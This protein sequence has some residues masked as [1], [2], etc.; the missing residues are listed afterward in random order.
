MGLSDSLYTEICKHQYVQLEM[1]HSD[2][3]TIDLVENQ[4]AITVHVVK[5]S[6]HF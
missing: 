2:R 3:L 4:H 6:E 5:Y 1:Q